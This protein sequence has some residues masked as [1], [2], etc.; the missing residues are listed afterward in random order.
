MNRFKIGNFRRPKFLD[1]LLRQPFVFHGCV[2]IIKIGP[3]AG[4]RISQSGAHNVIGMITGKLESFHMGGI[5]FG[6]P[7]N[8]FGSP[9]NPFGKDS[10]EPLTRAHLFDQGSHGL[11]IAPG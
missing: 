4:N 2:N 6:A 9:A 3:A 10:A 5:P 7:A 8:L 1:L 11:S